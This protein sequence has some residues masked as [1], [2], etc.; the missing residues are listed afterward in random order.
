[1]PRR[2]AGWYLSGVLSLWAGQHERGI[3]LQEEGLRA[4]SGA[5]SV[6]NTALIRLPLAESYIEMGDLR[7]ARHHLDSLSKHI[8]DFGELFYAPEMY[9]A[10]GRLLQA[11]G[12]TRD[13]VERAFT[14][15]LAVARSQGAR[16]FELRLAMNLARLRAEE[17]HR[18]EACELL[19]PVYT[20]FTE[21]F[22][23][24]DLKNA[25]ELLDR[26]A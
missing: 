4:L 10:L 20:W 2:R 14:D 25:K 16:L 5:G 1:L 15:G 21:G 7:R 9:D 19:A 24:A 8:E 11:E 23:T 26:L 3:E 13:R 17:S 22:D 12:A 18:R 6:G